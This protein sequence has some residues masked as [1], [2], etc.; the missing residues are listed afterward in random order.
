MFKNYFKITWRNIAKNKLYSSINI[1]GLATGLASF[2]IILLYLNYEL[3]YDT[4]DVSLKKVSRISLRDNADIR[5]NT[6]APLASLLLQKYPNAEAVTAI[7]PA[8]DYPT[9]LSAGDKKMYQVGLVTVDSC[10]LK[11]FPYRLSKGNPETALNRPDA[12]L[13]SEEVSYK[14]FGNNNPV[15]KTVTLYGALK[16]MIT[17]VFKKPNTPSHINAQVVM[18]DPWEKG[19]KFW[20]NYSYQAYIKVRQPVAD[21]LLENS[22]SGI[23]YNERL[24]KNGQSFEDYKKAGFQTA[25]LIDKVQD[26]HNFPKHGSSNFITVS[27]L[28]ILAILLLLAGAINFSNLSVAQSI[29]RAKEVGVRKVLGSGRKQLLFQFMSETSLQCI[30]SLALSVLLVLIALPYL[31]TSFNLNLAFLG[32]DNTVSIILQIALCLVI[33]IVLS[34]LYP[35]FF[36][37][38]FNITK[39]LKGNYSRG[40]GG[41]LFR[42]GLI[43]TQFIFSAFFIIGTIV[44]KTQMNF[45]EQKDKGFSGEQV[46]RLQTTQKTRDKDFETVRNL[47][48]TLPGVEKVSKSTFVPGDRWVDT[49]TSKFKYNGEEYRLNSVKVSTD[50]FNTLNIVLKEGRLFTNEYA[51]QHTRYAI[52]N[53]TAAKLLHITSAAGNT[54][55]FFRCDSV[56]V[57]IAGIVKDFNVQGFESSVQPVIYTIGNNACRF[58]SGGGLLVKLNN[59]HL[60]QSVAAITSAWKT[61]EPDYPINYSFLDDN[62]QQLLISYKRL[63]TIITF[64]AFI[65]ILIAVMGLFALTAF[66]SGQRTKEVGIRKVL[67]AT[68]VD[69]T[70]LLSRDFIRLVFI[71]VVITIPIS[72]WALDKWLQSFAY[73][74]NISWWMFLI[75]AI[76]IAVIS[77]VTVCSQAIKTALANPVKSLKTE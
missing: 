39:V 1:V 34:G 62:F 23:Y 28:L 76:V 47:L 27:I 32:Q 15:G 36:L 30:T 57:Q 48:L 52:I 70:T 60:Q 56:P 42:N 14:L 61:I 68:L 18:R 38:Q 2:I 49:S 5:Q 25:L 13:V 69:L 54:I 59:S 21:S 26:I 10:F 24:K 29:S 46:M 8:G 19:N 63:D 75:A 55:Y 31:N 71:A 51:D 43:V 45:M 72:W 40:K 4:W 33:V 65:A 74:I 22:I 53:E 35:S 6:P 3:S 37:S 41:N 67:G 50:Y 9:L 58:Q 64:F 16:G 17:G 73:H 44:V 12:V 77:I 66:L 11:V 7:Q 20:E